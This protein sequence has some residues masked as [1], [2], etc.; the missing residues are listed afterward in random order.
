MPPR[1]DK[2]RSAVPPLRGAGLGPVSK[3][4]HVLVVLGAA[5]CA[6]DGSSQ[7]DRSPDAPSPDAAVD[8]PATLP[9]GGELAE[10]FCDQP[11]CCDRSV[12]PPTIQ[13][14][15]TCCWSTTCE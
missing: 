5:S 10:C 3:L 6:D 8:A 7:R 4:F 14:G 2:Q 13:E 11:T 9:D 12:S 15:F 1:L